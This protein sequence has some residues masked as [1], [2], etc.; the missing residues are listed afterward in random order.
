MRLFL[1]VRFSA[2]IMDALCDAIQRLKVCCESGRFTE[3]ENLHLT[4]VFLGEIPS[5]KVNLVKEAM[6]TAQIP[7]FAV[8]IGGVG[9][10]RRP[11]GD[12]FW[13]GVERSSGLL[14]AYGELCEK[15]EEKGF[16]M[17]FSM[18]NSI[19]KR[20]FRPHLTLGRGVV[21]KK[22]CVSGKVDVPPMR[23]KV[24]T[25]SLM[26]SDRVGGKLKYTEIYV[27]KL[28]PQTV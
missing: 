15:L 4:L 21:L 13:A 17:E 16:P 2:E 23:M 20:P 12:I 1:A 22:D 8:C 26:R 9:C 6:Q 18:E 27:K 11:G 10:F 25:V 3:R 14:A 19:G 28:I 24:E 5:S 7:A